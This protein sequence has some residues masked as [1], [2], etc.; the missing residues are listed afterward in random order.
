VGFSFQ[1]I[2][3]EVRDLLRYVR[4]HGCKTIAIT[5]SP[6]NALAIEADVVLVAPVIGTTFG[7]SL[8]APLTMVNALTN[9]VAARDKRRS[10]RVLNKVKEEWEKRP[11]FCDPRQGDS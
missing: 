8:V 6:I 10:L 3:R 1:R 11:I 7:L 9:S 4:P 5:D 2:H